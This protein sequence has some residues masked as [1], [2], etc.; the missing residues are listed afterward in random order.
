MEELIAA[1]LFQHH[2]CPVPGR[3]QLVI[4]EKPACYVLGEKKLYPPIPFI[5]F[6]SQPC[7]SDDLLNYISLRLQVPVEAARQ[8]LDNYSARLEKLDA[9]AEMVIP[10]AGK[11][12]TTTEG[13]L[14]FKSISAVEHFR[15]PV[16]AERVI[17]PQATHAILVGD[18]ESNSAQMAEFYSESTRVTGGKWWIG[19]LL[20]F[21]IAIAMIIMYYSDRGTENWGNGNP[22]P[23]AE[24]HP[25]YNT[26]GQ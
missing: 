23:A 25:T 9:F 5:E 2:Y 1:Y 18:K 21:I 7:S 17:H 3:G 8:G 10:G 6:N 24:E 14:V 13:E 16:H 19:A 4:K 22:V 26:P 12:Y 15:P 20:L 11:F